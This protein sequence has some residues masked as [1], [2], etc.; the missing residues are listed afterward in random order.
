MAAV[1]IESQAAAD[2][3]RAALSPAARAALGRLSWV[4][5]VDS[6]NSV[7]LR[8]AATLP[9][10]AALVVDAQQAGRGRRGRTWQSPPSANLYL[11]LFARLRRPIGALGGLSLALGIGCAEALR[12]AELGE[13]GLKW[14][15]DLVARDRKL[16][17]L[18]VELA[19]ER[20][21]RAAAVIGLGLNL[22]MP[23]DAAAGIDQPWIDL[24]TLGGAAARTVWAARMLD[25]L[26]AAVD[27]FDAHGFSPFAARWPAVDALAGRMLAVQSADGEQVGIGVGI[28]A[29][30][31]LRLGAADGS[32][33]LFHSADVSVRAR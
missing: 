31:A 23:A 13:V 14:P 16:G 33:R 6:S 3:L 7:L 11:S 25:A 26:L 15:N 4:P 24:A 22:A 17:G 10:R 5:E 32:E 21:G 29:D 27:C 18:L 19:G 9:D 2:G 1:S 20:D 28:D 30:G 8:E 12:A